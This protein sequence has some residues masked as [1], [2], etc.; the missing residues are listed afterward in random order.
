MELR[1]LGR[2]GL[3]V[4]VLGFGTMSFG[5]RGM[6]EAVGTTGVEDAR[7]QID[8]CLDAGVNLFDTADVYSQG[9][10]EEILG[11]ALAGRRERVVL[12]TK[13]NGRMGDGPNDS[14]QSRAHIVAACEASLRR[15]G[16]DWIDLYQVHSWD[17]LT[18]LAETL[19]ALDDLV[20]A[21]KVRYIGCSN[22]AAWH[23][24]KALATSERLGL[25]P[26][27]TQQI[28]YSLLI[29]DVEYELVPIAIAERVGILAWSPLAGGLLSGK[30][31]RDQP[32]DPGTRRGQ[33]GDAGHFDLD[34]AFDAIEVIREIADGHGVSVAQVAVNWLTQRA[35]VSSVLIGA[36]T[37]EQLA[38]NLHAASWQLTDDELAR[39]DELTRPPLL[40]PYWHQQRS[41][42]GRL[43]PADVWPRP[44]VRAV[45]C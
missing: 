18:P 25:Q 13:L 35:G 15:L 11:Q 1:T 29:R 17:G 30:F 45:G 19:S 36:R 39:L 12:A 31:R 24:M 21:G 8:R 37:D 10:S 33:Q 40:Y 22:Y 14:G 34:R 3:R 43:S 16:T 4:S 32:P 9:L 6:Q 20:H 41:A 27:A 42:A 28:N 5:G 38:D 23:L 26:Y 7:R 2:T 44:S